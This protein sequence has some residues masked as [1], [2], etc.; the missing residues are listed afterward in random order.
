MIQP[1]PIDISR[2]S[3]N[4]EFADAY[5]EGARPKRIVISPSDPVQNF[6]KPEWQHMF[7]RSAGRYPEQF[8]AE[9]IAYQIGLM[10]GVPVPP[11]H[12]AYD[13]ETG[14]C[15]ALIEWFYEEGEEQFVAAGYYFY[16]RIRNF[17]RKLGAQ[18]NLLTAQQLNEEHI[19]D[20]Q[21]YDF[22]S[23]MLFDTIIG[24]TDR[25]QDN[26]GY[27]AKVITRSKSVARRKHEKFAVKWNFAPW[28][29]NG[30]SLGHEHFERKF[31]AW[32][33]VALDRYINRGQHHFR[34]APD[35]LERVGHVESM[36]FIS[37]HNALTK[38][39]LLKKLKMFNPS[40]LSS[41]L[42][43][44]VMLPMPENGRLS[45]ARADFIYRLT[46]RRVEIAMDALN[47]KY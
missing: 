20:R 9:V 4:T 19:G 38:S 36:R 22:W 27:L 40:T 35:R 43:H 33:G 13:S 26:W 15:G 39:L 14:E 32:D 6:I 1:N 45:R 24:N 29:D 47:G 10:I 17:D 46:C 28:F 16:Q 3:R 34:F 41:I 42:C 18:H 37:T 12:A 30:T 44:F 7:K 23:M 8:W 21:I 25:H 31:S 2:W 11:A 5:P